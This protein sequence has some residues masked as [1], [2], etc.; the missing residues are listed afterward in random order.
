MTRNLDNEKKW[1]NNNYKRIEFR[2]KKEVGEQFIDLLKSQNISVNNWCN[3]Q[4]K[5]Y[6]QKNKKNS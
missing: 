4:V 1:L 5:K 3:E 2:V 6:L